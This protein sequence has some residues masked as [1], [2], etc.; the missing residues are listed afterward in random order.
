MAKI[1]LNRFPDPG[2]KYEPRNFFELIRILES[3]IQQLNSTYPVDSE[4]NPK[5]R[6]GILVDNEL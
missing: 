4:E 5:L 2:Q 6:L 1:T 3:L